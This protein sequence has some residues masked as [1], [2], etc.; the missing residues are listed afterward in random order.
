MS[1]VKRTENGIQLVLTSQEIHVLNNLLEQFLELL[2]DSSVEGHHH[3]PLMAMMGI[4][5]NDNPPDDPVLRRLFPNAYKEEEEAAEFR[6]YTEYGLREK[7]RAQAHHIYEALATYDEEWSAEKPIDLGALEVIINDDEVMIWLSAINDL[8]LALG[9]R[10]GIGES[11]ERTTKDLERL[12]ED[13]PT[14]AVFAVYSWLGWL[15]QS[16]LDEVLS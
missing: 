10:L 12:N 13:D 5:S 15:Q 7:K 16:L 2:G 4:V 8:R 14:R 9:V 11:P 1:A 3:D 6:R